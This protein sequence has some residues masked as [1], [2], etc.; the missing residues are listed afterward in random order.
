MSGFLEGF[1]EED[2]PVIPQRPAPPAA[3]ATST[4]SNNKRPPPPT[5][6]ATLDLT[7]SPPL[8]AS[9]TPPQLPRFGSSS[10]PS[11]NGASSSTSG[12]AGAP[13]HPPP[14]TDNARPALSLPMSGGI[15]S[16]PKL[17]S[18]KGEAG[19]G[20]VAAV[21]MAG[22]ARSSS[23]SGSAAGQASLATAG[24]ARPTKFVP[25]RRENRVSSGHATPSG[26]GFAAYGG[27]TPSTLS[28]AASPASSASSSTSTARQTPAVLQPI[29]TASA[30]QFINQG[31][32]GQRS[33]GP[34]SAS[35]LSPLQQQPYAPWSQPSAHQQALGRVPIISGQT[36]RI[37]S[38][39]IGQQHGA[40][41]VASS[42][43][44]GSSRHP[45]QTPAQASIAKITR[46]YYSNQKTQQ[47]HHSASSSRSSS[48]HASP[49]PFSALQH[50]QQQPHASTSS[51]KGKSRE[52]ID[53]TADDG[54]SPT[55]SDDEVII[56]ETPFCI[57]QLTSLA[58]I[59]YPVAEL[60]P[61]AP[62]P[63][64]PGA[65]PSNPP[66][67]P[68]PITSPLPVHI[69][70]GQKQNMNET[71]RLSTP[72][73]HE[74]FGVMEH[75]VAN[76]VAD[77]F[78]DGYSGTGVTSGGNGKL[79]CEA[80]V[81]R[82]GERNVSVALLLPAF[83]IAGDPMMLP[84]HLLLFA[85]PFDIPYISKVLDEN[86]IYLEHPAMYNPAMHNGYRYSNPH[87]PAPG[88]GVSDQRRRERMNGGLYSSYSRVSQPVKQ[89]DVQRQ[90]VDDV[91]RD[92]KSGADLEEKEPAAL[93]ATKLYPHQKQALSFL[94][95][96]EALVQ[97]PETAKPDESVLVSLWKRKVD[98]YGRPLG[99]MSIVTDLE[100][101]GNEPPPQ[102][103]GCILADD[104]GLGKT[105]VVISLVATTL[106]EAKIWAQ[107]KPEKDKV[108]KRF[109]GVGDKKK[110][111]L[112]DFKSQLYGVEPNAALSSFLGTHNQS[113]KPL[114]KKKEAKLKREQKRADAADSRFEKLVTK[115]R[116][117]LIVCPLSTVQNWES[118]FEEHVVK[119]ENSSSFEI[120]IEKGWG[121]GEEEDKKPLRGKAKARE[122]ELERE[123][124]KGRGAISVY[125]YH[126][127][128][129]LQDA[130]KLAD[131]DVVIT[132]F[133]TLGTEYSRQVRAEEEREEEAK[134]KSEDS[135]DALE[136]YDENGFLLTK[137]KVE[138]TDSK[139]GKR[140]RK[141]KKIEGSGLSPL[142]Q[143]Q[144]FR[145]VLDEAHIIKEHT[146]IQARAACELSAS[147]RTAL[148]GTPLQN[149]LNDL[150]S[151]VRFL[152]LE[153]FTDR[154][155]WTQHIGALA[156]VGDPLGVSRLQLIM[157]HLALRRTKDS[158]DK[159]GKPILTLPP[160]TQ[161]IV[162]L[163]FD[164]AERAF[165][166]SHHTRYRH[167]FAKLEETDSVMKNYCSILQELLRLRQICVH[168]A[169]VRDSEDVSG[170]DIVETIKQHGI[171]KSRA[172]QLLSLM[173]DSGAAQCSECGYEM[174]SANPANAAEDLAEV[175]EKKPKKRK[176]GKASSSATASAACSDN[177]EAPIS[178]LKS[179]VTRCQ[180]LF[181]RRCFQDKVCPKWP[182]QPSEDATNKVVCS[183]CRSEIAPSLD[184]V[185]LGAR[186]LEQALEA[187]ADDELLASATGKKLKGTRFVEHSTKTRALISDLLPYSRANPASENYDGSINFD[188]IPLEEQPIGF[189]PVRGEVVKSVVFSQWTKL[190][191][192]VGDSLDGVNI[193]YGRLDGGMNRDQR[194]RAM[195]AFK[196]DPASEV[197][198]V[199]LRAG[200]VGLNLTA[201]RRVYLMEPFWNPAVE[202]QAIDRIHRLGQT[203][204]VQTIRYVISTSIEENMLKIQKRKTELANMSLGQ[205]LSKSELAK[206]RMEDLKL[207]LS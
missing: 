193:K 134:E 15:Y 176:L 100:I 138:E 86:A 175:V 40:A 73:S 106:E 83:R 91:F 126:G 16:P 51:S 197:L 142:Q 3:R 205:T 112:D 147:R 96:R 78:G 149:S 48:H 12:A 186:E 61:P 174:V 152:R 74:V 188:D 88:G 64:P 124:Q 99:W 18:G 158:T 184:V 146:T 75:R 59:L 122:M 19:G 182:L 84:L 4:S 171:S 135:D 38:T 24:A 167:D 141:R 30:W 39:F 63:P 95:D 128:S 127:N 70:R 27:G 67:A 207:L 107:G 145:V 35:A 57:G 85:R 194:T 109:D 166:S 41:P 6:P 159:E 20:A 62:P 80:A 150:F 5:L 72:V 56:D 49:L 36:A 125:V 68:K 202:N 103:R 55:P 79:W 87:N 1:F 14:S 89:A 34:T 206:Q 104:M 179:V 54:A 58:L 170:S 187:A 76:V 37:P 7:N 108:D 31:Q 53:L 60:L 153:P 113:S 93:V 65:D 199:S 177:E 32:A 29:S 130:V 44:S 118:Q 185:E 28:A 200:G 139:D 121:D 9:P 10:S 66:P 196:T 136:V 43:G 137:P 117:T 111:K 69:F 204:P 33:A 42:S 26:E 180:H 114:S 172:I 25:T 131:Y 116:A 132:T 156:K 181:C 201:G 22:G 143:I 133:S 77:L 23:S 52:V 192:R 129:R 92:L 123:R 178:E 164:T 101:Q 13:P 102:S 21:P 151:L 47:H 71:L 155:V 154:N 160:N 11:L 97:I 81:I 8:A 168:M 120:P 169:L 115:S 46:D 82:R 119:G 45:T 163:P 50:S 148:S 203:M 110:P 190:L 162:Y 198:L 94:L 98:P 161:R 105:I 183:V 90:Q 140:K 165:Y 191:D 2:D 189:Q 17:D 144:W 173:R 157:R 195:E